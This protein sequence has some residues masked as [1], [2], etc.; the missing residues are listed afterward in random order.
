MLCTESSEAA[1]ED[2]G[3]EDM[4]TFPTR[5][6]DY[7]SMEELAGETAGTHRQE[8]KVEVLLTR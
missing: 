6:Y 8:A 1:E 7:L 5:F 4:S 2:P 3:Q